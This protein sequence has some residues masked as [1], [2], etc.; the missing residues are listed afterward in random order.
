MQGTLCH[1][2]AAAF[3]GRRLREEYGT[4]LAHARDAGRILRGGLIPHQERAASPRHARDQ[5]QVLDR[6]RH[7]VHRG[8]RSTCPIAKL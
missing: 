5:G 7:A 6:D 3:R 8:Q 4:R 2:L 1:D